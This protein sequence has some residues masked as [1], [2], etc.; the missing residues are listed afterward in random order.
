MGMLLYEQ[1]RAA[2]ALKLL[3]GALRFRQSSGD[4]G[5]SGVVLFLNALEQKMGAEAF[6]RLKQGM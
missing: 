4:S 6:A 1:G 2:E 3:F 5:A